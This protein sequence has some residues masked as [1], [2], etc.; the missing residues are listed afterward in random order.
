MGIHNKSGP[1]FRMQYGRQ[2]PRRKSIWFRDKLRTAGAAK[3]WTSEQIDNR[4]RETNQR[5][6]HKSIRA[7]SL[8]LRTNFTVNSRMHRFAVDMPGRTEASPDFPCQ[9]RFSEEATFH[10]SG[11]V[12]RYS[13]RI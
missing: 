1:G 2:P 9:E 12:D 10:V 11:L 5:S 13:C 6:W 8:Q 7:A 3:T 4:N